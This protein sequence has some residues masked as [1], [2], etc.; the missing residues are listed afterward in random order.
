MSLRSYML[1]ALDGIVDGLSERII[2]SVHD[3]TLHHALNRTL[4]IADPVNIKSSINSSSSAS[5]IKEYLPTPEFLR[6]NIDPI[7]DDFVQSLT[8][9]SLLKEKDKLKQV[10]SVGPDSVKIKGDEHLKDLLIRY[11]YDSLYLSQVLLVLTFNMIII[12]CE[13]KKKTNRI[14][15]SKRRSLDELKKFNASCLVECSDIFSFIS[16]NS[17]LDLRNEEEEEE[18]DDI[19]SIDDNEVYFHHR[20]LND[21][22]SDNSSSDYEI[23]YNLSL[24]S[25]HLCNYFHALD[26]ND[27]PDY[28]IPEGE[29]SCNSESKGLKVFNLNRSI[30]NFNLIECH[31]NAFSPKISELFE[32]LF[33]CERL[34]LLLPSNHYDLYEFRVN[35]PI[36]YLD[37]PKD[38]H[39]RE[40]SY[41][42]EEL[43]RLF[44]EFEKV[45]IHDT[46][47]VNIGFF[48]GFCNLKVNDLANRFETGSSSKYSAFRD[49]VNQISNHDFNSSFMFMGIVR[50]LLL[51]KLLSYFGLDRE[52]YDVEIYKIVEGLNSQ[53]KDKKHEVIIVAISNFQLQGYLKAVQDVV[54]RDV[55][56]SDLNLDMES[57]GKEF[58]TAV[59]C[60]LDGRN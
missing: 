8:V 14:H 21:E 3:A 18:D 59:S 30:S 60:Y 48:E 34:F 36:A 45:L 43:F 1:N 20:A 49:R 35:G 19:E 10:L 9:S 37:L 50:Q 24:S 5:N 41:E 15:C 28:S 16:I 47:E 11:R 52:T 22:C 6:E 25:L 32:K 42:S 29:R 7:S 44:V 13:I 38:S 31:D 33:I 12:I 27:V 4:H 26:D 56:G 53:L 55:E 46:S 54:N 2:N 23:F 58:V 39:R 57:T 17:F 40:T 51:F